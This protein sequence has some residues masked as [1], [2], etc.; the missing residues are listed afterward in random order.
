MIFHYSGRNR[1]WLKSFFPKSDERRNAL[2]KFDCDRRGIQ[3]FLLKGGIVKD[4]RRTGWFGFKCELLLRPVDD[5]RAA[6]QEA[7]QHN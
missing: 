3:Q 1:Y 7:T 4:D 6:R 2:G 5:R